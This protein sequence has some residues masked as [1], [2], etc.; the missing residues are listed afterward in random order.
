MAIGSMNKIRK[1]IIPNKE[2][3]LV[4]RTRSANTATMIR[5]GITPAIPFFTIFLPDFVFENKPRVREPN[6]AGIR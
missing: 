6:N 1:P 4:M 2:P 5:T 3:P